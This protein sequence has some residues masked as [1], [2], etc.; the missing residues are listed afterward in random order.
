MRA[1]WEKAGLQ[2][3]DTRVIRIRIGYTDFNDL[4]QSYSVPVGPAV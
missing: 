3:I 1:V 2:A 4:W